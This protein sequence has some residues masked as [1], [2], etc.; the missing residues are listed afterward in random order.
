MALFGF[1][2][3]SPVE[4]TDKIENVGVTKARLPLGA[5]LMLSL[6]AGAFIGLGALYS[7][8]VRSD[9]SLGFAA[10]QLLSGAVFSLGL[11]MVVVAG[12]ELFT[13][14]NLLVM[15]WASRKIT[16]RELLRSWGIVLLG[17]LAGA[18]GLACLVVLSAHPAMNH[19][20]VGAEYLKIATLK[21]QLPFASAFFSGLLC[22][23]LVCMA[24]WMA[25]AG[26]S[27][28]DKA[29]AILFPISAF[30]AAGFEHSVA[31]MYL[32]PVAMLI[33]LTAPAAGPEPVLWS[34]FLS[35]MLP[36]ILGNITGGSVFV[37]GVYHVIYRRNKLT[38]T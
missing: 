4:I 5:M 21:T 32:I 2:A 35:N 18:V 20:A 10:R 27:V 36:V 37:G 30:V 7:V 1:N 9:P 28:T 33:Q 23:S 38:G 19:G 3:F 11:L 6:L 15:A 26:R 14:N 29:A 13:G 8:V 12:A 16:T 31:N 17:N 25:M 34:G 24:V 22:N